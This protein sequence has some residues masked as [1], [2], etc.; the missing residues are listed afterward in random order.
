MIL[1][2]DNHTSHLVSTFCKPY[3][4]IEHGSIYQIEKID[5]ARKRY[6]Q[7]DVIYFLDPNK[8]ESI[9]KMADDFPPD[10]EDTL[11]YD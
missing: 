9:K 11:S 8:S 7:S 10:E 4:L 2:V 1:V 5:K 3:E 6:P